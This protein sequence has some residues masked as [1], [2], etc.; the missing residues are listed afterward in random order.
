MFPDID[1]NKYS[2]WLTFFTIAVPIFL[3]F[4]S[5]LNNVYK[6]IKTIRKELTP[7]GG[8]SLRDA[9]NRVE[10]RIEGIE[11]AQHISWDFETVAIFRTDGQ[12]NCIWVNQTYL[13][14]VKR[15]KDFLLAK[16]WESCIHPD[17]REKVVKEWKFACEDN[18]NIDMNYRYLDVEQNVI[19][20]RVRAFG[21]NKTGYIGFISKIP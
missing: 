18:R 8:S 2:N 11:F 13:D 12:G 3:G 16:G 17:D 6:E 10:I 4:C 21:S 19:N 5:W 20:C 1:I 15:G 9:I 7:N 14:L